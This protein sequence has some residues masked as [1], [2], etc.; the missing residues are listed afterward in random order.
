M[1]TIAELK[2]R[3]LKGNEWC[4]DL[5]K[6]C[7]ATT[8][9]E[10]LWKQNMLAFEKGTRKLEQ[11]CTELEAA[12]W[13]ACLYETM[14]CKEHRGDIT[15][16]ACPLTPWPQKE[17]PEMQQAWDELKSANHKEQEEIKW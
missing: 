9:N 12:G 7:Q 14:K 5:W 4:N 11:L 16:W 3:V 13:E 8:D 17:T 1:R 10:V 15:C 2:P 6:R